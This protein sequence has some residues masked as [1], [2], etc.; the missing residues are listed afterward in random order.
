MP[1]EGQNSFKWR[2]FLDL[3]L[4]AAYHNARSQI[5]SE[6]SLVATSGSEKRFLMNS[7]KEPEPAPGS[8]AERLAPGSSARR[9]LK[10]ALRESV[11]SV[12]VGWREEFISG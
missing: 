11:G 3:D 6:I 10:K 12:C 7:P 4:E 2:F 9:I 1:S 5:F 8:G